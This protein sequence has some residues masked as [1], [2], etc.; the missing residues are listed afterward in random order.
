MQ[1][2]Q[3]PDKEKYDGYV[4]EGGGGDWGRMSVEIA[5][6]GLAHTGPAPG[7]PSYLTHE[8]LGVYPYLSKIMQTPFAGPGGV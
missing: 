3:R 1:P 7:D 2:E 4:K 8:Q 6:K 5:G